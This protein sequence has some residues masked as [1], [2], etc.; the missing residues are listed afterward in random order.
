[1]KYVER[2][3]FLD[4]IR[5]FAN[6][7]NVK[8]ITGVR[9]SGKSTMIKELEKVVDGKILH[10]N[11]E[12][13]NNRKYRD[14]EAVYGYIRDSISEGAEIVAVVAFAVAGYARK[15]RQRQCF[16]V[17]LLHV[18]HAS[19]KVLGKGIIFRRFAEL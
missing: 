16:L 5:P 8:I 7:G 13:W 15:K 18:I 19:D 6:N 14:P 10:I 11:M 2:S 1:M 12:L 17:M 3:L 4:R 9:R